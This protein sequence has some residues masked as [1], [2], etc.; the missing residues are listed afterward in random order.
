[1]AGPRR[2]SCEELQIYVHVNKYVLLINAL[3]ARHTS[4]CVWGYCDLTASTSQPASQPARLRLMADGALRFGWV[5][6]QQ[7]LHYD[8]GIIS[9][10]NCSTIWP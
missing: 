10:V 8:C 9:C 5:N 7:L 3:G 4:L 2:S 1:M 6:V